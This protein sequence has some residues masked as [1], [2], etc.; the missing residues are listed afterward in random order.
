MK[1]VSNKEQNLRTKSWITNSILV[2]I[3]N[4][5]RIHRK[6]CRAKST[7]T[8]NELHNK[9]KISKIVKE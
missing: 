7:K 3:R 6:M 8:K 4:K 5:N 2:L 9:F 1:Q